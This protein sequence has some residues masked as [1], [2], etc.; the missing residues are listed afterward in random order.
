MSYLWAHKIQGELCMLFYFSKK[1]L[2]HSYHHIKA[3]LD[4]REEK[5]QRLIN[6]LDSL[7]ILYKILGKI[8]FCSSA[9]YS[10]LLS[11]TLGLRYSL[12]SLEYTKLYIYLLVSTFRNL[13]ST[14]FMIK[15]KIEFTQK[16]PTSN[17]IF[18]SISFFLLH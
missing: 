1:W 5:D 10:T 8:H 17:I 14:K 6:V 18:V 4:P 16:C 11:S 7:S 13:F 15:H 3:K 2:E 12:D 9:I